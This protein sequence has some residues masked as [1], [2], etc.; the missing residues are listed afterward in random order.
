LGWGEFLDADNKSNK[1]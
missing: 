1:I